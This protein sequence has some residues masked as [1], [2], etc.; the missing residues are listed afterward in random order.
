MLHWKGILGSPP[1]TFVKFIQG[2]TGNYHDE[3]SRTPVRDVPIEL[4]SRFIGKTSPG[5]SPAEPKE[6]DWV[7]L[8]NL[9][10][11]PFEK[12]RQVIEQTALLGIPIVLQGERG[13]GKTFLARYYHERRQIYRPQPATRDGRP[14]TPSS[15]SF[16]RFP[17]N[18][19]AGP[20]A[21]NFVCVT[22][23]EYADLHELRD[24]LFG[25]AKGSWTGA[26]EEY[27]GLLGLAHGGTLF[28]DEIHHLD[29]TLQASLLGVLNNRRYRPKGASCEVESHF[30]LV[31]AT[32][33]PQWRAKLADDFRDRIERVVLEVPPFRLL[34]R[35]DL[36]DLWL[37]WEF[38][39]RRRCRECGIEYCEA[40]ED[41]RA[42]VLAALRHQ[43]LLGNWRDLMRLADQVLL[44]LT[45]ARGGRPTALTWNRDQLEKA[46][47]QTFRALRD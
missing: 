46:I 8:E 36:A 24:N 2:D 18:A 13:T 27:H 37:F 33:D 30:D 32:N 47:F 28:L 3:E 22:L 25:W 4:L 10:G 35:H 26:E 9:R 40:P 34:Q 6:G 41:C 20:E 19:P 39:L 14:R 5:A 1:G 16:L 23:S 11:E 43:P 29:R 21:P 42:L 45:A 15:K 31:V 44:F 17:S 12:L 7:S 38:T